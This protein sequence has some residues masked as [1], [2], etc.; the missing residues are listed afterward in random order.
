MVNMVNIHGFWSAPLAHQNSPLWYKKHVRRILHCSGTPPPRR[1]NKR[2]A[3]QAPAKA[4]DQK[5]VAQKCRSFE[6][7]SEIM[8]CVR[9]RGFPH[10]GGF[11]PS[12]ESS[13]IIKLLKLETCFETT[14]SKPS[15]CQKK[16]VGW[17]HAVRA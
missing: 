8:A 3:G 9:A 12:N 13:G 10:T 16:Q 11:K 5:R 1:L 6:L 15:I 14:K 2:S 7:R 17:S 4:A